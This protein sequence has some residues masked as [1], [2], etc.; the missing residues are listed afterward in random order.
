VKCHEVLGNVCLNGG[1]AATGREVSFH[2]KLFTDIDQIEE[3]VGQCL[4]YWQCS[5]IC[6]GGVLVSNL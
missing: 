6:G 3:E 1:S 2:C 4:F 5:G